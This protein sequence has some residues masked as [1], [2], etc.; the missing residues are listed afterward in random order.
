MSSALQVIEAR[1]T[2]SGLFEGEELREIVAELAA[3]EGQDAEGLLRALVRGKRLTSYQAREI[4]AGRGKY[5]VLGNYVILDRLGHGGMGVVYKAQHL[6]MQRIVA[7]KVLSPDFTK[8]PEALRRFQREVVAAARLV[9][10]NIVTAYD[11]AEAKDTHFLVMEYVPGKTLAQLVKET[12]TFSARQAIW[13][14][15]QGARGLAYAHEHGVIHRDVKPSNLLYDAEGKVKVLD[16]G[17]AR[18]DAL[19]N[20]RQAELTATGD[21]MGTVDFMAPEQAESTKLA[22]ARSDVYSLGMSLWYLLTGRPCYER[23]SLPAK[24]VAHRTAPPPSLFGARPDVPQELD[25]VFQ[26]LVA[27]YP[28]DRYQSMNE[29]LAALEQC[30]NQLGE[31]TQALSDENELTVRLASITPRDDETEVFFRAP[32]D[33]ARRSQSL[34][35]TVQ[36]ASRPLP[37]AAR[38]ARD[39]IL[40]AILGA[41]LAGAAMIL[42]TVW[43]LLPARGGNV[44]V[45]VTDG[46]V[47]LTI[48]NGAVKIV[49]AVKQRLTLRAGEHDLAVKRGETELAEKFTVGSGKATRLAID[50]VGGV[51][52]VK[53]DGK[54]LLNVTLGTSAAPPARRVLEFAP[55]GK[56]EVASLELDR[57]GALTLEAY[58]TAEEVADG[59]SGVLLGTPQQFAVY[60]DPKTQRLSLESRHENG[61]HVVGPVEVAP[62]RRTHVAAVRSGKEHRLYVEGIL[63][64]RKTI[65]SPLVKSQEAFTLGGEFAGRVEEVRVSN[66]ARYDEG[67]MPAKRFEPDDET[68]ALYHVTQVGGDTLVDAS[69]HG[70]DGRI[71]SAIWVRCN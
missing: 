25:A 60:L 67:F 5:L 65:E 22:D 47:E 52:Q 8:D 45:E 70:H 63:V 66:A 15:V 51:L 57:D 13:C 14:L 42:L 55:G 30:L 54:L 38:P 26:K 49:G 56:V 46:D 11:A 18:L 21:V 31:A 62:G 3:E 29:A 9:H 58:V 50:V 61:E 19:G 40:P 10:P 28:A 69:G 20:S 53:Q 12:G 35:A 64:G 48:D 23:D 71:E 17:L 34:G 2:E 6:R 43:L 44:L 68:L 16:L 37:E 1:L 27:K 59:K 24:I 4:G 33:T 36:A 41:F 7:L 32:Q 39:R